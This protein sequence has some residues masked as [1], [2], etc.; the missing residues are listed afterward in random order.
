MP[1]F[2]T[3]LNIT[4][5]MAILITKIKL[6]ES[7][8][9]DKFGQKEDKNSVAPHLDQSRSSTSKGF[10]IRNLA[11][12]ALDQHLIIPK[13]SRFGSVDQ[14]DAVIFSNRKIRTEQTPV[15]A[16]LAKQQLKNPRFFQFGKK[17]NSRKI[18]EKRIPKRN[19][20][21]WPTIMLIK[22]VNNSRLLTQ[23]DGRRNKKSF[24]RKIFN[25]SH[26]NSVRRLKS[27]ILGSRRRRFWERV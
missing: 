16:S 2:I 15:D 27:E 26:L 24:I 5:L 11:L 21:T 3:N 1:S 10:D 6:Q 19:Q 23:A 18:S 7:T 13:M 25:R 22:K 4:L 12:S 9:M 8:L 17:Q 14:L 20:Q